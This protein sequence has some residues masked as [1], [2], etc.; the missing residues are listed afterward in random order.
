M[1]A[2]KNHNF[3]LIRFIKQL[4]LSSSAAL[5]YAQ[6]VFVNLD[7]HAQ[8]NELPKVD[9]LGMMGY[10]MHYNGK[11]LTVHVGVFVSTYNDPDLIRHIELMDAVSD[12]LAP[13]KQVPVFNVDDPSNL[14]PAS[15]LQVAGDGTIDPTGREGTRSLQ[16]LTVRMLGGQTV[17][18]RQP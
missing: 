16:V 3:S 6:P 18:S 4:G 11:L 5:G 2:F 14:V 15:W 7:A 9:L 8:L 13:E 1:S 12:A 17:G 10:A